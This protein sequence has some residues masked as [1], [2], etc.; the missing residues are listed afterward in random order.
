MAT[1]RRRSRSSGAGGLGPFGLF[2][3]LAAIGVL[4]HYWWVILIV[5]GVVGL[6]VGIVRSAKTPPAV[7]RPQKPSTPP[8]PGPV[9]AP[10]RPAP[11]SEDLA[12]QMR[13]T[14]QVRRTRDMQDWDYEWIRLMHPEKS[15]RELSEIAN[16]HFARGRSI[17]MNYE[18]AGPRD[19]GPEPPAEAVRVPEDHQ[20]AKP[21]SPD[22]H[23][24]RGPDD[25]ISPVWPRGP[26][27]LPFRPDEAV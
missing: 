4:I 12:G 5:L 18:W 1:K 11:V 10:P 7:A 6:T 21:E 20:S 24:V 2:L 15:S 17:G 13:A 9:T 23:A 25:G 19:S 16:A 22:E 27:T 26:R 14:K 3:A 8:K